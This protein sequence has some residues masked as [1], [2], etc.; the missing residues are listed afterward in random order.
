MI[1][2]LNFYLSAL[3]GLLLCGPAVAQNG[4]FADAIYVNGDIVTIDAVRPT[5]EALAVKDGM[6][7]A[8]GDRKTIESENKGPATRLIDLSGKA[9]LP[10]FLDA[11]SH[12]ISSLSVANQ[13]SV[14]AP[15]V[16]PGSDPQS[17]VATLVEFKQQHNVPKG[18]VIQ[19]Y[20]Y[21]ENVM[22]DGR[23]LNRDDLDAAF[24]DNPV[25]VG[26]VS[27]HGAVMNSAA[28]K[29]WNIT[30]ETV[31]PPGG[32]IVRKPGTNE[33]YGLIMETAYLP[34]F[35]SLPQP[36]PEQEIE[37]SRAGQMLYAQAGITTAHEGAT[38]AA[39]LA[40]M[41]R[42]SD[43]GANI[44][45]LI[46]YP[47]ITDLDKVLETNPVADWGATWTASRLAASRSP[48]T[49]LRRARP[50]TSPRPISRAV[51][52]ERRT[53]RVNSPSRRRSSTKPSKRSMISA[54]R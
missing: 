44:I 28:L 40:I 33:P 38:H 52:V 5:A 7:L 4:Q 31:T 6:I 41:R 8:V 42:V 53:G 22:P 14:Y 16:G 50:H 24:P 46:A 25:L 35:A 27:M 48:S 12:Y 47:F 34:V 18:E 49:A 11:H 39:D 37:W 36:T 10:G 13:A 43:A 51:R 9:L 45:D 21:D 29:K 3:A 2:Q 19:A 15:P 1:K 20:G 32:V 54:C 30:A 17:I 26:H 23:L